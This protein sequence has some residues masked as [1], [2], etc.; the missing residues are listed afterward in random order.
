MAIDV[1]KTRP[2]TATL[3]LEITLQLP[4]RA[5][6]SIFILFVVVI[7]ELFQSNYFSYTARRIIKSKK[8]W[9]TLP[10][11]ILTEIMNYN[12]LLWWLP[13]QRRVVLVFGDL[14]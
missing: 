13:W 7:I 4:V 6:Q 3:R 1:K 5:R 2:R 10:V 11:T 8:Q 14:D 9:N 12:R